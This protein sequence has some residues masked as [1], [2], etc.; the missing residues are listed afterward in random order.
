[1][2]GLYFFCFHRRNN[3]IWFP[4]C[5][6][7]ELLSTAVKLPLLQGALFEVKI[8]C[9]N[10]LFTSVLMTSGLNDL[11]LK[12]DM[13]VKVCTVISNDL[14]LNVKISVEVLSVINF[15]Q[16]NLSHVLHETSLYTNS[17]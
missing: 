8:Y 10:M 6:D 3:I 13:L 9:G 15:H 12:A 2:N 1:M 17:H 7:Y 4:V 16:E 5:K 11:S 14:W